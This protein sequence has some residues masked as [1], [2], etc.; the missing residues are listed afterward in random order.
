MPRPPLATVEDLQA[1]FGDETIDDT[2]KALSL[3]ERA[4]AIVRAYAHATWLDDEE[5]AVVDV[6]AD[7]PGVVVSMVERATRNPT[8]ATQE[9]VGPFGRSFGAEAASRLYLTAA[10]KLVIR[11]AVGGTGGLRTVGTTRGPLETTTAADDLWP[12]E[13]IET[14]PWPP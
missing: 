8:G 4:S 3:L 12:E 10:E 5:S 11:E 14:M 13:V 7:V 2:T 6:P 1:A 9:T